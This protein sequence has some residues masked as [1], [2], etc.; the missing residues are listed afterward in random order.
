VVAVVASLA[1]NLHLRRSEAD[2]HLLTH[3][4][5]VESRMTGLQLLLRTA[6]NSEQAY[7][8]AGRSDDLHRWRRTIDAADAILSKLRALADDDAELRDD[9]AA[10]EPALRRALEELREGVKLAEGGDR[11]GVLDALRARPGDGLDAIQEE[12]D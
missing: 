9:L 6:Q 7:L 3:V 8:L 2:T 1:T 4:I 10:L 12:I 5:A 11:A